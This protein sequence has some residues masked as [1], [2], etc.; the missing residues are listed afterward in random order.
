MAK[1]IPPSSRVARKANSTVTQL[2][3]KRV[4]LNKDQMRSKTMTAGEQA[5]EW[6]WGVR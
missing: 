6:G 2:L 4:D 1:V 5:S 3:A